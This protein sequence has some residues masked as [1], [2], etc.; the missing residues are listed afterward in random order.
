M[1]NVRPYNNKELLL[2]PPSVGDY[3]PKDDLA[4]VVDEAVEQIDLTPYYRKLSSVGNPSYD[5]ALE[6]KVWF[7]GYCVEAYSSRKIEDKLHRDI[8]FIYLAGMQKPD[9]RTISDFRKNNLNELRNSFVDIVQICHRL[10]MTKLGHIALDSKVM[11]AN[12]SAS[13]TYDEKEIIKERQEIE[14]E[15]EKYLQKANQTDEQEDKLYGPDK[16]GNELPEDIRKKEDRIKKIKR[17]AEQLSQAQEKLKTSGKK[18]INTTDEDAQFQKDKTRIIP[19]YRGQAVVDSTEQIIIATDVTNEQSDYAQL[20]PMLDKTLENID[21]IDPPMEKLKE[22]NNIS[23][24]KQD[25][26]EQDNEKRKINLTGDAGYNNGNNL[27]ELEKKKYKEKFEAYIPD[28]IYK[29]NTYPINR[30]EDNPQKKTFFDKSK[31]IYHKDIDKFECP[32]KKLLDY[33]SNFKQDGHLVFCYQCDSCKSCP[34]F[35]KCTT[36]ETGRT[37]HVSEHQ[38]LIDK[39][40]QKLSTKEGK[41]IYGKRKTIVEPVFGNMSHNLGFR[42]FL[43]RGIEKVKGEFSLMCNAHNLRKMARF[44]REMGLTLKEALVMSELMPVYSNS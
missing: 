37:I 39:M 43:L 27:A 41:K 15:I 44:T 24:D 23:N 5:P 13:N 32:N 16:C 21:K 12:A 3:L 36:S 18:K 9:F 1:S 17:I 28:S 42:E 30:K 10:G 33:V 35:S 11:K 40:R 25:N 7:Y 4:H 8:S 31:F 38:P 26:K 20:I 6:I 14:K 2:F 22:Q 34:L 19:G 29:N